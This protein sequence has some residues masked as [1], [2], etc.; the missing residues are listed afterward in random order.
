MPLKAD[1]SENR[2]NLGSCIGL[3]FYT[4]AP[5]IYHD[6]VPFFFLVGKRGGGTKLPKTRVLYSCVHGLLVLN[7]IHG[8]SP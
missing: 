6:C 2:A 1:V 3:P 8:I 7:I 4:P 5:P